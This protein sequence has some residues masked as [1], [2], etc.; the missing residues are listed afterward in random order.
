MKKVRSICP[1]CCLGCG[2]EL[3]VDDGRIVG[4]EYLPDHPNEGSLCSRGNTSYEIIQHPERLATPLVREGDEFKSTSWDYALKFLSN[5]LIEIRSKHGPHSIGVIASARMSNEDCYV[6]QKFARIVLGTANID[7]PARLTHAATLKVL[8]DSL[9]YPWATCSLDLIESSDIIFMI[10]ANPFEVNPV[11]ARRILRA[12]DRGAIIIVVDPRRTKTSWKSDLHLQVKPGRDLELLLSILNVIVSS[13][14][15]K[16]EAWSVKGFEEIAKLSESYAPEVV[17]S[18]V[19]VSS[20]MI[21]EAALRLALSKKPIVMYSHGITQQLRALDTLRALIALSTA[22]GVFFSGGLIPLTDRSNMQGASDVGC[23]AEY[24]PG[25]EPTSRGLTIAEMVKAAERGDLKALV[26]IGFDLASSL[27][28]FE[29][30]RNVLRNLD[31]L[32]VIDIF[33]NETAKLAHVILPACSWAEYDGTYTNIEGR[34]QRAFKAIEPFN[35]ARPTWLILSELATIMGSKA[36]HYISW[37]DVFKEMTLA[38]KQYSEL[39]IDEVS[40]VGGQLVKKNFKAELK[41]EPL[42]LKLE[43]P[44]SRPDKFTLIAGRATHHLDNGDLTR[45]LSFAMKQLPG[46]YIEVSQEDASKL[47]L[48]EGDEVEVRGARESLK[49]KV[50]L[51]PKGLSSTL[52][53][54]IHFHPC[55]PVSLMDLEIDE[56]TKA[57]QLKHVNVELVKSG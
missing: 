57:P 37:V 30:V 5:K 1:F 22:I 24:G 36:L 8:V 17:E 52:F 47:G 15:V 16:E 51:A 20:K 38:V 46:P 7:S 53:M 11:L 12:R 56:E 32:V 14:M 34:V 40:R 23:L 35:D 2:L 31:L 39:S 42:K 50:K 45:K 21:R 54:P 27:P 48:S 4:V 6:T 26:V 9:G 3:L 43:P 33:P 55:S 10:G 28:S 44:K 41:L 29:Y 13:K 19:G 18:D 49:V 25:Y